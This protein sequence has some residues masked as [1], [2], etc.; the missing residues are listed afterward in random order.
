MSNAAITVIQGPLAVTHAAG[1]VTFI[2][3]GRSVVEIRSPLTVVLALLP[4][5]FVLKGVVRAVPSSSAVFMAVSVAE[6][7]PLV[8][9]TGIVAL[10]IG[11]YPLTL[12]LDA[13]QSSE[14]D[15]L[16][17]VLD[18]RHLNASV[19]DRNNRS[20][21][22]PHGQPRRVSRV[23]RRTHPTATT[24]INTLRYP[25]RSEVHTGVPAAHC[26]TVAEPVFTPVGAVVRL[27]LGRSRRARGRLVVV[28]NPERGGE[29]VVRLLVEREGR[30]ILRAWAASTLLL[31]V[32]A[33]A[34]SMTACG[35]WV[36]FAA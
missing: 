31:I 2:F 8:A 26:E 30:R 7:V 14:F 17:L 4:F 32:C 12:R 19:T 28:R 6:K 15:C 18:S 3:D 11:L 1:E 16:A 13:A 34:A 23:Q 9:I 29:T 33:S 20:Q 25:R 27:H 24:A 5:P 36:R 35:V 22:S 21:Y 10:K